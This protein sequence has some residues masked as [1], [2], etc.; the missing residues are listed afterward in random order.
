MI[1]VE[2]SAD[3][4][5][6]LM[7]KFAAHFCPG[8]AEPGRPLHALCAAAS[9]VGYAQLMRAIALPPPPSA[10]PRGVLPTAVS[11]PVLPPAALPPTAPASDHSGGGEISSGGILHGDPNPGNVLYNKGRREALL[12]DFQDTAAGAPGVVDLARLLISSMHPASRAKLQE[13]IVQAYLQAYQ[14]QQQQQEL[15]EQQQEQGEQQG[16]GAETA[17]G[18]AGMSPKPELPHSQPLSP[19]L[20]LSSSFKRDLLLALLADAMLIMASVAF[21]LEA[22]SPALFYALGERSIMCLRDH[23]EEMLAVVREV[24]VQGNT[25]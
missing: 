13:D 10:L 22:R 14:Q 5:A 16:A 19:P 17:A 9:Q 1:P 12:I 7:L 8:E 20:P 24:A 21:S 25:G 4:L 3:K 18:L 23:C 15:Q 2:R 11:P 6:A